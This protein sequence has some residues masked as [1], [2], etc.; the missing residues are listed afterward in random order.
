MNAQFWVRRAARF[1]ISAAVVMVFG[2]A[3]EQKTPETPPQSAAPAPAPA[4]APAAAMTPTPAPTAVAG[5]DARKPA[6]EATKRANAA[7]KAYLNFNDKQD[8]EDAQRGLVA[9]PDKLTIKNEKGEVVWDLES[10]KAYI[11]DDKPAPDT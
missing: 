6:T 3:G 2:C 8:F 11:G 5:A 4:P 1:S 7:L 9:K 10:Y